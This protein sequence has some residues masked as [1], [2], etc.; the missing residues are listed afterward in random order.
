MN[1]G[2]RKTHELT[3]GDEC[4]FHRTRILN[5]QHTACIHFTK[6]NKTKDVFYSAGKYRIFN[7]LHIMSYLCFTN[8]GTIIC[9]I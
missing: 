8:I 6:Q 1:I 3:N 5:F 4:N 9:S 7:M 2:V